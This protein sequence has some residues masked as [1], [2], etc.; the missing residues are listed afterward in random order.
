MMLRF[1]KKKERDQSVEAFQKYSDV[2]C[3]SFNACRYSISKMTAD[4]DA[5]SSNQFMQDFLGEGE[6]LDQWK[7]LH[8]EREGLVA[9]VMGFSK[10]TTQKMEVVLQRMS[11]KTE[12]KTFQDSYQGFC[13]REAAAKAHVLQKKSFELRQK[14]VYFYEKV[15]CDRQTTV[16]KE[17]LKQVLTGVLL[18]TGAC[19]GMA[20][21]AAN[22][23][24]LATDSLALRIGAASIMDRAFEASTAQ[25]ERSL[26]ALPSKQRIEKFSKN[27][28]NRA[29]SYLERLESEPIDASIHQCVQAV[30]NDTTELS[31]SART[32]CTRLIEIIILEGNKLS[33]TCKSS[34]S[35]PDSTDN[36]EQIMRSV[37]LVISAAQMF[38]GKRGKQ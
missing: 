32:Q 3:D 35:Q 21:L 30:Y 34:Q 11:N 6:D 20:F 26:A 9:E 25:I 19:C 28:I 17:K 22:P 1:L 23:G 27:D 29:L 4:T 13:S 5:N 37:G 7:Q 24:A 18:V 14:T 36:K 16:E 33:S 38:K 10:A 8:I 2:A 15:Q 31:A 12:C